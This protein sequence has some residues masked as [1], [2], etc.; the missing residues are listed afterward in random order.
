MPAPSQLSARFDRYPRFEELSAWLHEFAD[1]FPDLIELSTIGESF[2]RR[3]LWLLT[4]TNRATGPAA[5][6][7]AL[8]LDGN[9]HASELTASV[10]LVHLVQHLC[11]GYG[12]DPKVTRALDT[13]TFYIVPR[14]NPDGAE[15]AL[16][17]VPR[18]VRSTTRPWPLTEQLDG[19]VAGDIDHDGRQLQMRVEDPN[20]PWKPF[21]ADPRLLVPRDPDEEGPGRYYR[22]LAE[23]RIQGYDGMT[24]RTARQLAGIDSN[25]NFPNDWARKVENAPTGAGDYP[26]SEPEVAALVRAVTER[27]NITGYFA[28]HTFSGVHLRAFGNK[29]DDALAAEDLWTYQELGKHATEIT[30]YPSISVYHDFR[31]HPKS[32][33]T[34]TGSDWAFDHL[35]VYAWTTE[36]WSPL[37]VAGID[38]PHPIDWY[39]DHPI[40]D[41]LKLLAWVD[42]HVPDGYV[43]WYPY[44][45]PELGPVELGGWHVARVFRNPPP[46]M[47]EAE[48]APHSELAVFHALCSPLL[49]HR[50][51]VV[52][53][54]GAGVDA[55]AWRVRVAVENAGWMNTNVTKQALERGVVQPLVARIT[56]PEGAELASGTARLELGQL[57]GR[58]LKSTAIH[59]FGSSDDTT[60]RAVAEWI[61]RAPAGTVVEVEARH[62]RAGVVTTS[63]TLE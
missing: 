33:I 50:E 36:F 3:P 1:Q 63:V 25:R 23:G 39:R 2:E 13:R 12:G 31:Y 17:E 20:G 48:I 52:E 43:D 49:R 21:G 32:V 44:D 58:A 9:I 60:D 8:W 38:D 4:V 54:V 30:G 42:E 45:H 46:D 34:G 28:Y 22:V 35:G 18:I 15:L 61:V 37:R 57:T 53:P 14:V 40:D 59:Q 7:P 16:A 11:V 41:E 26:T 56:L 10:A 55:S 62:D 24:V 47:L 51:T 19:L 5:D 6:K 27:P 29:S